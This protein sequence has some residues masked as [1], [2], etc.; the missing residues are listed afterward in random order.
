[1]TFR[2]HD[3]QVLK[4]HIPASLMHTDYGS[5]QISDCKHTPNPDKTNSIPFIENAPQKYNE[6]N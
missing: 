3:Y 4:K 1:M 5:L 2:V 6:I